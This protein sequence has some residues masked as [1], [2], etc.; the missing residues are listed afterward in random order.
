MGKKWGKYLFGNG[1][2]SN[3]VSEKQLKVMK[4]VKIEREQIR[5]YCRCEIC[6]GMFDVT[7]RERS[8]FCGKGCR[9]KD[10]YR[11]KKVK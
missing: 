7:G 11:R 9:D 6:E 5:I 1:I 2:F 4:R 10:Y 3:I 8:R